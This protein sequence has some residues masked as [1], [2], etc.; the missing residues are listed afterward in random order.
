MPSPHI[1][2]SKP[3]KMNS[4]L[5]PIARYSRGEYDRARML[6]VMSSHCRVDY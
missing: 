6:L 1:E 2:P 3:A 5:A 4:T